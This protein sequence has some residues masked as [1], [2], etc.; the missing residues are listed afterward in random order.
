MSG[1][2]KDWWIAI[3]GTAYAA[4]LLAII[5]TAVHWATNS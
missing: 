4:I 5:M 3:A 1:E 2:R